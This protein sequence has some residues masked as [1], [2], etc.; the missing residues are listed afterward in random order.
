MAAVT[1]DPQ[2]LAGPS[3]R[4]A[5]EGLIDELEGGPTLVCFDGAWPGG[6]TAITRTW[7][8]A[9]PAWLLGRC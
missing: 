5:L 4:P 2:L 7:K 1:V 9:W 8:N 3:G 6:V